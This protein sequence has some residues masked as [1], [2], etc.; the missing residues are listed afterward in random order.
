MKGPEKSINQGYCLPHLGKNFS[1]RPGV[2]FHVHKSICTAS[3]I[4]GSKN[5]VS[6]TGPDFKL[7]G[8]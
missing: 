6:Y 7:V 3:I 5:N 2:I 4:S 1:V 8:Y